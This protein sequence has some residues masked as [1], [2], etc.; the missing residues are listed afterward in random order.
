MFS[1]VMV[2]GDR[3]LLWRCLNTC[4]PMEAGIS[5]LVLLCLCVQPL[6][7]LWS[8]LSRVLASP[9]PVLAVLSPMPWVGREQL[10]CWMG[11]PCSWG[12]FTL[13]QSACCSCSACWLYLHGAHGLCIR[14]RMNSAHPGISAAQ[15]G[16]CC[17]QQGHRWGFN[18]SGLASSG[19]PCAQPCAHPAALQWAARAL[20]LLGTFW[21]GQE[22]QDPP[23]AGLGAVWGLWLCPL[24]APSCPWSTRVPLPGG[25]RDLP[26]LGGSQGPELLPP[27]PCPAGLVTACWLWHC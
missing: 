10:G 22:Q 1:Q 11:Y 16:F 7:S 26:C 18:A 3:A 4:L 19:S 13:L 2:R 8:C 27:E 25:D 9:A 17:Q 12:C 21:E 6:L 14:H 5:F 15:T 23:W 20:L 24:P